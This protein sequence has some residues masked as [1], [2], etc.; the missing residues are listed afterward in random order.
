[1]PDT[2]SFYR[3]EKKDT[4]AWVFLNRPEKKNAMGPDA[5]RE[6]IP[7]FADI[8]ADDAIRVAVIAGEGKD[9][10]AGIDLMGMAPMIPT[11]RDWDMSA[12]GKVRLFKDIF[13]LQDAMTCV[14]KCSKPVICCFHGYSIGAAL[15]LGSACDIRLASEDAK[16]SLREAAVSF[17]ADVGVL[18]R[19]PLIVGQGV[20]RE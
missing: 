3:V 15:D 19:L 7:I 1:M 9:F 5:W 10:S 11:M 20:T 12:R 13:P 18:Q 2:Y 16:I 4:V 17:I 14:E 8:D 6:I